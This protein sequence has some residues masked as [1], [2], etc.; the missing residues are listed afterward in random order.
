[1]NFKT[2]IKKN[3]TQDFDRKLTIKKTQQVTKGITFS[4]VL[5]MKIM[6][7]AKPEDFTRKVCLY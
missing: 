5:N 1:M 7:E 6:Q 3:M 4:K 2:Q